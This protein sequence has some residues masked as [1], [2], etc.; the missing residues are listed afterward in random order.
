[1]V[2]SSCFVPCYL[3]SISLLPLPCLRVCLFVC[4]KGRFAFYI[5]NWDLKLLFSIESQLKEDLDIRE[6]KK[7]VWEIESELRHETIQ[8][9]AFS[10][11]RTKSY[12]KRSEHRVGRE[13]L[14]QSCGLTTSISSFCMFFIST[15]FFSLLL[16]WLHPLP[17]ESKKQYK[18]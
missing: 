10:T 11:L 5:E 17:L 3:L 8:G 16:P 18:N 12:W 14:R 7:D 15:I 2:L 6:G 9:S 4:D 13:S 1:M